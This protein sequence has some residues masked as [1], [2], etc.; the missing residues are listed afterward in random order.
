MLDISPQI[1]DASVQE[2]IQPENAGSV[3]KDRSK[4]T[5][6]I[7]GRLLA[8]L[9]RKNQTAQLREAEHSALSEASVLSET[10]AVSASKDDK[11][12]KPVLA[13]LR[14][15]E[16]KKNQDAGE[17]VSSRKPRLPEKTPKKADADSEEL[18]LTETASAASVVELA[19][20]T[21]S[22]D[23]VNTADA[24]N[25]AGAVTG[26]APEDELR[27]TRLPETVEKE[28]VS[29]PGGKKQEKTGDGFS[30]EKA[31]FSPVFSGK[32]PEQ[33]EET[34]RE[35]AKPEGPDGSRNRR[36]GR[37]TV[38]DQRTAV[39]RETPPDLR[40][41]EPSR[42]AERELIVE[43]RPAGERTFAGESRG[44]ETAAETGPGGFAG[45]LAE[46]L[47]GDLSSDIV[48]QAA[49]VLRDGGAGTIRLSLKPET[50]G[51]VK[52]HLEMAENKITGHI[53]VESEEALR[54]FE[55]EVHTLEQAF[56]DSGFADASLD[57]SGNGG[58]WQEREAGEIVPFFSERFAAS[59]YDSASEPGTFSGITGGG[60][61]TVDLLV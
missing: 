34:L 7:F 15:R 49:I 31:Q 37:V 23:A 8:G 58:S 20:A 46:Q 18:S 16:T 38:E 45:L 19:S 43:L 2:R 61:S 25:T 39:S 55:K 22:P 29:G 11:K 32:K 28:A 60:F 41:Q 47:A 5:G 9:L 26:S 21:V 17:L 57:L 35:D 13:G 3:K 50:L 40:V 24:A 48:K 54:A 51:K 1:S 10:A 30:P 56:R 33:A 44:T 36:K 42:G 14:V 52:I 53:F 59:N 12:T 4:D 6:L 27:E